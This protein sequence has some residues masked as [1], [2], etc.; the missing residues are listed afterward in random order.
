M[1]K[2]VKV[3]NTRLT[4]RRFRSWS[5]FLAVSL[6]VTW[7]TNPAVGCHYFLPGPAV[8]LATV[9]IAATNFSVIGL[10]VCL[11]VPWHSCLGYRHAGCLQLSHCR[12]TEMCGLRTHPQT[13]VDPL[14]VELPPSA[15]G[16]TSR[17]PRGDTLFD[18]CHC[19][20]VQLAVCVTGDITDAK[21]EDREG[22]RQF[23][24]EWKQ[25]DQALCDCGILD[26]TVWLDTRGNHGLCVCVCLSVT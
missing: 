14:R 21:Q 20:F 1:S 9:K 22:S 7:V 25:Y 3:T 6:L 11:S 4:T 23:E 18:L 13:D 24:D 12:P 17:H 8:T 10:S 2:K 19:W 26:K 15:G 16:M 5:R